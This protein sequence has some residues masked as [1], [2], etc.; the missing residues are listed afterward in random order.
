MV[1]AKVLDLWFDLPSYFMFYNIIE[2]S[3]YNSI[4]NRGI[5][6]TINK[7]LINNVSKPLEILCL[8][9]DDVDDNYI[10]TQEELQDY[11]RTQM[12]KILELK[13]Y[14][15]EKEGKDYTLEEVF[16]IWAKNY[17]V[18]FRKYWHVKKIL[19]LI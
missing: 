12:E 14:L 15:K 18:Q 1:N 8:L 2:P 13:L 4:I 10:M 16:D 3:Y 11:N 6:S 9:S 7:M 5:F 17:S 19:S